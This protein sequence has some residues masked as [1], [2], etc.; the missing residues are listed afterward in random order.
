MADL[1]AAGVPSDTA[2]AAVMAL[3][4]DLADAQY[5]AFRR[6]VEQDIA[7]GASPSAALGVRM[8][9]LAAE[10]MLGPTAEPGSQTPPKKRKP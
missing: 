4:G 6:N 1:V 2:I 7:L 10:D 8:A 9:G 5:L 3:A